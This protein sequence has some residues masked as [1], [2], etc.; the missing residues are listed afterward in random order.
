M[1]FAVITETAH[2]AFCIQILLIHALGFDFRRYL[3]RI[4]SRLYTCYTHDGTSCILTFPVIVKTLSCGLPVLLILHTYSPPVVKTPLFV[5]CNLSF[6]P[7]K[8][9]MNSCKRFHLYL[10]R[11][12]E[13]VNAPGN[14]FRNLFKNVEIFQAASALTTLCALLALRKWFSF[15]PGT[16]GRLPVPRRHHTERPLSGFRLS[17][18]GQWTLRP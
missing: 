4:M 18:P 6:F 5:L 2:N 8:P 14:T 12:G 7:Q 17:M 10:Q 16:P 3:E 11:F 13:K 15:L 9:F 1:G